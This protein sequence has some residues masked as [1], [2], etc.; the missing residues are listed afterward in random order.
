MSNCT[1]FLLCPPKTN[2][3][4]VFAII[5]FIIGVHLF[6]SIY[7]FLIGVTHSL[8]IDIT[9]KRAGHTGIILS[10]K[11]AKPALL[12]ADTVWKAANQAGLIL[13]AA[14]ISNHKGGGGEGIRMIGG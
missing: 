1:H 8:K 13:F 12:N 7:S 10:E 2:N 11:R 9:G 6:P 3:Y 4:N 5:T 14:A